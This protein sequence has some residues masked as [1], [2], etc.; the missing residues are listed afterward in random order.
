MPPIW[1]RSRS[2]SACKRGRFPHLMQQVEDGG[3]LLRHRVVQLVIGVCRIAQQPGLLGA[4]RHDLADQVVVVGVAPVGAPVGPGLV[5]FLAQVPVGR[6]GQER[7]DRGAQQRDDIAGPQARARLPPAPPLRGHSRA[8]RRGRLPPAQAARTARPPGHAGRTAWSGSPSAPRSPP[9]GAWRPRPA[10]RRCGR[11]PD[12]CAPAAAS[13]RF[14]GPARR[15]WRRGRRRGRTE[16]GSAR[17]SRCT[18][19]AWGCNRGRSPQAPRW[20]GWSSG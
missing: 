20:C 17:S 1:I 2:A 7:L 8:G 13:G 3:R 16:R 18:A 10:R 4:K 11:T 14:P 6:E 12:S 19:P 9:C 15:A 5:G